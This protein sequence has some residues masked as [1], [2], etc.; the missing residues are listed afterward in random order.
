[1]W[2]SLGRENRRDFMGRLDVGTNGMGET[3][4]VRENMGREIEWR[5]I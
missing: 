4:G 5:G 1:M 3:G 2:I